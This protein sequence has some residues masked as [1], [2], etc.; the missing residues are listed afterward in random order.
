MF[1][2]SAFSPAFL[3][4]NS[5]MLD[6]SGARSLCGWSSSSVPILLVRLSVSF[7]MSSSG[8]SFNTLDYS[9]DSL[10]VLSFLE[11]TF[12]SASSMS[13]HFCPSSVVYLLCR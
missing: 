2:G 9:E 7:P 1:I 4:A 12:A 8:Y 5:A 11:V 10:L 3:P 13:N 6:R